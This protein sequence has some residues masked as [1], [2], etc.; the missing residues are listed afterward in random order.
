MSEMRLSLLSRRQLFC[1]FGCGVYR[2]SKRT[3]TV[4]VETLDA[5]DFMTMSFGTQMSGLAQTE[6]DWDGFLLDKKM[7]GKHGKKRP[8]HKSVVF[9]SEQNLSEAALVVQ[10]VVQ[11]YGST[12][13]GQLVR[14]FVLPWRTIVEQLKKDWMQAFKIPPR[15]WEEMIA[16]AF[17]QDGYDEVVL[18][19]RSGDHGRDVVAIKKGIGC[20]RIIG[21]VK[22]Y[23]PG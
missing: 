12:P 19:P 14:A 6:E 17:D 13:E 1:C 5:A 3:P 2:P 11:P 22:A 10:G 15:I 23:A 4:D 8:S 16:A 21:S 7:R 9:I 20:I 18:T